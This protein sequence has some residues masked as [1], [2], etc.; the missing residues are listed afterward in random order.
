[1]SGKSNCEHCNNYIYDDEYDC[2]VCDMNLDEDE[3]VRFL[4]GDYYDCPY[5]ASDD[6]YE[7]VRKQN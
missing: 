1:M 2:Y 3:M 4:T 6:E 5:Y 7:I